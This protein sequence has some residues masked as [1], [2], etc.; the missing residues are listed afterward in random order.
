[1]CNEL[2]I[3]F[4]RLLCEGGKNKETHV[5]FTDLLVDK[6]KLESLLKKII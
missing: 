1:M 6:N 2:D 5:N 4:H 3:Q